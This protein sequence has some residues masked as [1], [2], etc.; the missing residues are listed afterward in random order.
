[1]FQGNIQMYNDLNNKEQD[2]HLIPWEI[3]EKFGQKVRESRETDK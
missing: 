1:M 3:S 2:S